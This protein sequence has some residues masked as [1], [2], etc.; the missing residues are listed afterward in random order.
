MECFS[1][2]HNPENHELVAAGNFAFQQY[3]TLNWIHHAE[4]VFNLDIVRDVKNLNSLEDFCRLLLSHHGEISSTHLET[5]KS[6]P[7]KQNKWDLKSGLSRVKDAYEAVFSIE[8]EK[9]SDGKVCLSNFEN[10]SHFFFLDSIP[11]SF[12]KLRQVRSVLEML[13]ASRTKAAAIFQEAYGTK[14]FKCPILS[15]F[16]FLEGF[17]SQEMRDKHETTHQGQQLSCTHDGCDYSIIGFSSMKQL[18]KHMAEHETPPKEVQF[19]RVKQCSLRTSLEYAIDKD[20]DLAVRALLSEFSAL[21]FYETDFLGRAL[22]Q[23]SCKAIK[24]LLWKFRLE[25]YESFINLEI[26]QV[27]ELAVDNDDVEMASLAI[28]TSPRILLERE[29][30]DSLL[31]TAVVHGNAKMM[32]IFFRNQFQHK[33]DL[34]W[35]KDRDHFIA[36]ATNGHDE[37]LN[38]LIDIYGTAP[39]LMVYLYKLMIH[40][41]SKGHDSTV[42]LLL[43]KSLELNADSFY[44]SYLQELAPDVEK[45][46]AKL[47]TQVVVTDAA[48]IAAVDAPVDVWGD[49]AVDVAVNATV[50]A[51]V[52][53][54]LDAGDFDKLVRLLHVGMRY[55]SEFNRVLVLAA[56]QGNCSV[57]SL[58]FNSG[59]DVNSTT[60]QFAL[61]EAV[62]RGHE[63]VAKLFLR[64]PRFKVMNNEVLDFIPHSSN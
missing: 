50:N 3:A 21:Q 5:L 24:I 4:T 58:L 6:S 15:C 2:L 49:V 34:S 39:Q 31:K 30:L 53:A 64:N 17:T 43:K 41:A 19:P 11:Y 25:N 45:M 54:A 48:V 36:A 27:I 46:L 38:L 62:N 63:A 18:V 61:R 23:R 13:A 37:V 47:M 8:Y 12:Q 22:R 9:V 7:A 52:N 59:F 14:I 33:R 16:G 29:F 44:P 28:N 32:A 56:S 35:T 26:A 10:R 57:V 20:D 60:A 55:R 42:R 40:A 51:A 1:D